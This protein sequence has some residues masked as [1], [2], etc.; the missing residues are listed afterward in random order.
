MRPTLGTPV[1]EQSLPC[2][3]FGYFE[4]NIT[5][6]TCYVHGVGFRRLCRWPSQWSFNSLSEYARG[7]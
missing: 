3:R 1:N 7:I 4:C 6:N 2:E 5:Q